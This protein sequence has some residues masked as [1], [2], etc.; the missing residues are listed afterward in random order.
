MLTD[1]TP[2][3]IS[4]ELANITGVF[5]DN[6]YY[7]LNENK[8]VVGHGHL[9][10]DKNEVEITSLLLANNTSYLHMK[11]VETISK[12]LANEKILLQIDK[13]SNTA[14]LNS[15]PIPSELVEEKHI[16]HLDVLQEDYVYT[17]YLV[18]DEE[19]LDIVSKTFINSLP[20]YKIPF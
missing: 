18:S 10:N 17:F 2:V 6:Y 20:F 4:K 7:L 13:V 8:A 3:I 16:R 9:L 15:V 12:I 1:I 5:K 19:F 11:K 14:L